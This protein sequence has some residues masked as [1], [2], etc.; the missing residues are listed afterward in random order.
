MNEYDFNVAVIGAGPG[1]Y[2]AALRAAQNGLSVVC[3]EK[4]ALGGTCLNVGCIP[5]KSLLHSSEAYDWIKKSSKEEGISVKNATFDLSAMMQ[6]KE[7]IVKTL[8][9]GIDFQFKKGKIEHIKGNASFADSHT[10]VVGERKIT[11]KNI[12][13][14]TGSESIALPFLP[15]DEKY[16]VSSTGALSF[17]SVPQRFVV[18]GAGAIGLELASV[19]A[20]LGSDV[21]VIEMLDVVTPTM[22]GAVSKELLQSLKKQGI[23][24]FLGAKVKSGCVQGKNVTLTFEHENQE[25][26]IT[27]DAVLVAIGRKPYTKDLG[28]ANIGVVPTAKGFIPVD[29]NFK[30]ILKTAV[31]DGEVMQDFESQSFVVVGEHSQM[32][33]A[34]TTANG[35]DS[36]DCVNLPSSIANFR[37]LHSHIYAIGDTISGPMLA[38]RASHEG[39]AV[40]DLIAGKQAHI[41]YMSIPNVIYT[42]PEAASVG[43]SEAEA[44]AAG[45]DITLGVSLFRSNGRAYCNGNTEGFVK[46]IGDKKSGRLVGLHIVGAAAS[47]MIAEGVVALDMK[48]TVSDI[49]HACHPHP[50]LSETIMEACQQ[51][52]LRD[53]KK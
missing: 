44:R 46:V 15:F 47:E 18:V 24:F 9:D 51:S 53:E 41:N 25:K 34:P 27:A 5:S 33:K 52:L 11:A 19:Y 12:I 20:R 36:K 3:I 31:Q 13:I 21:S 39:V 8:V 38:H 10:L 32:V 48:A 28:L 2:I 17:P 45:L 35:C 26:S 37:I 40:A 22:D 42:H 1:G 49:A 16:I 4:E 30:V 50:T 14:A 23:Q 29:A 6:R 7:K 43:F